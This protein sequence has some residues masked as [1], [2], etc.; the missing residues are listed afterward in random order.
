MAFVNDQNETPYKT[1]D[2]EREIT[3]F[4]MG[5][6]GRDP[7]HYYELHVKDKIMKFSAYYQIEKLGRLNEEG[8]EMANV[9]YSIFQVTIPKDFDFEKAELRQLITEALQAYGFLYQTK[10]VNQVSV[11]F[12]SRISTL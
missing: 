11:T 8:R 9:V 6:I 10:D 5:G 7:G 12:S 2:R 4:C 3:L 1:I